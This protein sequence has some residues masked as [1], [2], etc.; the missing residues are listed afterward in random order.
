M[1]AKLKC[2][3]LGVLITPIVYAQDL[4]QDLQ[5]FKKDFTSYITKRLKKHKVTGLSVT[6]MIDN[7]TI[8]VIKR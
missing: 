2:F 3:L 5:A 1:N 4:P 8:G 7:Q 6:L